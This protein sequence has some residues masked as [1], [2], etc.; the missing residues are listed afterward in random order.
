MALPQQQQQQQHASASGHNHHAGPQ[1]SEDGS[2]QDEHDRDEEGQMQRKSGRRA[3]SRRRKGRSEGQGNWTPQEHVALARAFHDLAIGFYI[4]AHGQ[5][6]SL[7]APTA[8]AQRDILLQ[9]FQVR[10]QEV[11][12]DAPDR[13]V[14]YHDLHRRWRDMRALHQ[15]VEERQAVEPERFTS[16]MRRAAVDARHYIS[17]VLEIEKGQGAVVLMVAP[18]ATAAAVP[19]GMPNGPHGMGEPTVLSLQH[20]AQ[21]QQ[22]QQQQ[23][24]P[25]GQTLVATSG[26]GMMSVVQHTHLQPLSP[27][28]VMMHGEAP[29]A[30]ADGGQLPQPQLPQVHAQHHR[31]PPQPPQQG[32]A[33]HHPHHHQV[34]MH[35]PHQPPQHHP[36]HMAAAGANPG[37]GGGAAAAAGMPAPGSPRGHHPHESDQAPAG[38]ALHL[39]VGAEPLD[40]QPPDKRPRLDGVAGLA[41]GGGMHMNGGGV[42]KAAEQVGLRGTGVVAEAIPL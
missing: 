20:H 13:P 40:H 23:Q 41:G 12:P 29:A 36:S 37:A 1:Q 25:T 35:P 24:H 8:S 2:S 33:Q 28:A 9:R 11:R 17:Q 32:H 19:S 26:P 6:I 22:Q 39:P 38:A 5:R 14:K 10:S 18:A 31:Q 21:Q 3:S 42:S 15:L 27:S 34:P 4:G 16:S 7:H 30:D